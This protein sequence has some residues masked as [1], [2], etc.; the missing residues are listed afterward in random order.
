MKKLSK[1]L[2]RHVLK[3][4]EYFTVPIA[5]LLWYVSPSILRWIDP[6]AATYDAGIFQV[7]LFTTIQFLI[8]NALAW[9]AF[10]LT[11]PGMYKMLDDE[12]ENKIMNNGAITTFEKIKIV[13]WVFS[14]YLICITLLS[15]V[16]G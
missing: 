5:L 11:F 16:I 4:H 12:I 10:R 6:T 8:Y 1:H 7:I 13:L 15:R 14:L 2:L 3:W 9:I